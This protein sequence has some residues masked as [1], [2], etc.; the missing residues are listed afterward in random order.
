MRRAG[1][2]IVTYN[3]EAD[4]A[5]CLQAA[6]ERSQDVVVVDNA[7]RDGTCDIVARQPGVRLIANKANRGF[8]AAANQG[9][10]ALDCDT[11]LL[12]N[13]DAVLCTAIE[14]LVDA[15]SDTQVAAASGQLVDFNGEPQKGFTVR[16]FPTPIRL[17]FEVMGW[18][19]LWPGNPVNR[20]YRCFDLDLEKPADV[21]QPAG[22][23]LM[24]RRDVWRRLHGMDEE[25]RPLWFE[26]VDYLR[27]AVD[28]G[29]SV[30]YVPSA[31]ARHW[32]GHSVRKLSPACRELYWYA[33]LLRYASKHFGQLGRKMV[34]VAVVFGSLPRMFGGV[35]VERS[36]NPIAVYGR[37]IRL[38]GRCLF[39]GR[40]RGAES[41]AA[42]GTIS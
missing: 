13:P 39:R 26:D 28:S 29:Y 23:F 40:I 31:A 15:C 20:R 7:S 14:D 6:V 25:F 41:F 35:I 9:V 22:A 24:V 16:R 30:R 34:C 32:G 2:V 42:A 37:V 8:A 10:A 18:N 3:S 36:L 21:E 33:S 4:I 1:I 38:G 11:V 27:R 12:L 5:A 17:V 19:R